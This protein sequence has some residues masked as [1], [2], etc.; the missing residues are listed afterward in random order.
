[1]IS[2]RNIQMT[3][4]EPNKHTE[5]V[6][7]DLEEKFESCKLEKTRINTTYTHYVEKYP[8]T[9]NLTIA[10]TE[11]IDISTQMQDLED[12]ID[13]FRIAASPNVG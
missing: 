12:E 8:M 6:L 7:K 4:I 1:M 9:T 13:S 10:G 3:N 11:L 2:Q 5:K